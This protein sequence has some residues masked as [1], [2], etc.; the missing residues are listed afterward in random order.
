MLKFAGLVGI[1]VTLA[2]PVEVTATYAASPTRPSARHGGVCTQINAELLADEKQL[3]YLT[4]QTIGPSNPIEQAAA[5]SAVTAL[6]AQISSSKAELRSHGCPAYPHVISSRNFVGS[7]LECDIADLQ[8]QMAH[9]I[10][11]PVE[12]KMVQVLAAGGHHPSDMSASGSPCDR[13][14]WKR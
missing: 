6:Y 4:A 2:L 8:A 1:I 9:P 7:A 3:G 10:T 14:R 5:N 11:D 13:S 12:E